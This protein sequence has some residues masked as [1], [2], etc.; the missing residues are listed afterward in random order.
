MW[1][2]AHNRLRCCK[3]RHEDSK[4]KESVTGSAWWTCSRSCCPSWSDASWTS[5]TSESYQLS[6]L[7]RLSLLRGELG[8]WL[9][10]GNLEGVLIGV[11]GALEVAHSQEATDLGRDASRRI[12][13]V[14]A[15]AFGDAGREFHA[16]LAADS[17][18]DAGCRQSANRQ[19]TPQHVT[20]FEARSSPSSILHGVM[21]LNAAKMCSCEGALVQI[22]C[23]LENRQDALDVD[24]FTKGLAQE[25][26]RFP[27]R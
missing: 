1:S 4:Y 13:G 27:R 7:N 12:L 10:F 2:Y 8:T 22:Q 5:R 21:K 9:Q 3:N 11:K 14:T 19:T 20:A 16:V 15:S 24:P 26:N 23:C 25:R 17:D 6:L 18:D